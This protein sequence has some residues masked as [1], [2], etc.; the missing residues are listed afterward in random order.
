[1]K[2]IKS[3]SKWLLA[4]VMR[5]RNSWEDLSE[6][7][8][9]KYY[10]LAEEVLQDYYSCNRVWSAWSSGTMTEDDFVLAREDNLILEDTARFLYDKVC[11]FI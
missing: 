5:R 6:K 3:I 11:A 10:S 4:A 7:E 1:M 8:R 2:R 9:V